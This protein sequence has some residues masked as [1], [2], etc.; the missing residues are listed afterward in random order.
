MILN[1]FGMGMTSL[2]DDH[3]GESIGPSKPS[4]I[5]SLGP[6]MRVPLPS[7]TLGAADPP[8]PPVPL[9]SP[10]VPV[11]VLVVVPAAPVLVAVLPLVPPAPGVLV[12]VGGGPRVSP[13]ADH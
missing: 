5:P 4:T 7:Q 6:R 9:P 1:E 13:R 12:V 8:D 2:N 10:P 11:V 3:P